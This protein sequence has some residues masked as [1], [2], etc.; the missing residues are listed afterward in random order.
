MRNNV[1]KA[2]KKTKILLISSKNIQPRAFQELCQEAVRL[3]CWHGVTK[4]SAKPVVFVVLVL[5]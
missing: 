5:Q 2:D 1:S 3:F 4:Y